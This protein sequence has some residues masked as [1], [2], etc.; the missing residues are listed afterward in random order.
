MKVCVCSVCYCGCVCECV[1]VGWWVCGWQLGGRHGPGEPSPSNWPF[2]LADGASRAT[3]TQ[4]HNGRGLL[5]SPSL[6]HPPTCHNLSHR[7][8]GKDTRSH[9]ALGSST[10]VGGG[11]RDCGRLNLERRNTKKKEMRKRQ[12]RR[13]RITVARTSTLWM[14]LLSIGFLRSESGMWSEP[15]D[16]GEQ[17]VQPLWRDATTQLLSLMKSITI[18]SSEKFSLHFKGDMSPPFTQTQTDT[19]THTHSNWALDCQ[20]SMFV[21]LSCDFLKIKLK[22]SRCA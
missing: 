2:F 13:R 14:P 12:T 21:F 4:H 7:R 1:W 9:T 5:T 6:H 11:G 15:L 19:H 17:L 10:S 16:H 20:T 18:G 3:A 8:E 22:M